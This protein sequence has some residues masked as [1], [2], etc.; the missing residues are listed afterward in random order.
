MCCWSCRAALWAARDS[1]FHSVEE[2]AVCPVRE[3]VRFASFQE[4]RGGT[5]GGIPSFILFQSWEVLSVPQS[6]QAASSS[7]QE[8]WRS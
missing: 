4:T 6:M 1:C 3:R 7:L 5:A 8:A 2:D